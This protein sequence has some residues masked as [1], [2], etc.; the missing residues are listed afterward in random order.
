MTK[1]FFSLLAA[2]FLASVTPT[3]ALWPQPRNLQA[4]SGT[5]QLSNG[6]DISFTG[7]LNSAPSDLRDAVS[8]TKQFLK[9]DKLGRLVVDRG[10][11]DKASAQKAKS[12]S[13]LTLSLEKGA[14]LKSITDEAQKPIES[15]DEAYTLTVPAD[16]SAATITANSTLGLFR[17]LTT[18]TQLWYE[19]DGMTYAL[20]VPI[21]IQDSPAYVCTLSLLYSN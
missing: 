4:G 7:S 5:L 6:F 12:L 1:T 10:Q 13:K 8:R 15:R 9:N 14:T 20:D 19:V 2:V 11:S 17:G 16:G 18:F 21:S 3:H